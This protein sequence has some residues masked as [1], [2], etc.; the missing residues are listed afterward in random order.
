MPVFLFVIIFLC[1]NCEKCDNLQHI[2]HLEKITKL[3]QQNIEYFKFIEHLEDKL[4]IYKNAS[5]KITYIATNKADNKNNYINNEKIEKLEKEID[6]MKRLSLIDKKLIAELK[7][8]QTKLVIAESKKPAAEKTTIFTESEEIAKLKKEIERLKQQLVQNNTSGSSE[9]IMA[10]IK[11]LKDTYKPNDAD[12]QKTIKEIKSDIEDKQDKGAA[13]ELYNTISEK[14]YNSNEEEKEKAIQDFNLISQTG[15]IAKAVE[16]ADKKNQEQQIL[17]IA[18]DYEDIYKQIMSTY[19]DKIARYDNLIEET[20]KSGSTVAKTNVVGSIPPPPTAPGVIPPPPPPN[21]VGAKKNTP[22][23]NKEE[24]SP[25]IYLLNLDFNRFKSALNSKG[26]G[27]ISV[28]ASMLNNIRSFAKSA[29]K[30]ELGAI[31]YYF[32]SNKDIA[33]N[34]Q[35][36]EF[37]KDI[38]TVY[39]TKNNNDKHVFMSNAE[40][41]DFAKNIYKNLKGFLKPDIGPIKK[42]IETFKDIK[43]AQKSSL[44][45]IIEFNKDKLDALDDN[46]KEKLINYLKY[47]SL[48]ELKNILYVLAHDWDFYEE[49]SKIGSLTRSMYDHI[50][51]RSIKNQEDG[52]I[53]V[54]TDSQQMNKLI[55]DLS[56]KYK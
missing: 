25:L 41:E 1:L 16:E 31:I 24:F 10:E 28:G 32:S 33:R 45:K 40:K 26:A 23:K 19:S 6:N 46:E 54:K 36:K 8:K 47:S 49:E 34:S 15:F 44:S 20:L 43:V 42:E 11:K 18:E 13:V 38:K 5:N 7:E 35:I 9:E 17:Q 37:L 56:K 50:K 21:L 39:N 3:E 53:I 55:E 12:I 22:L 2:S 52:E 14:Y 30:E 29:S 48:S 27:G 51:D 4:K